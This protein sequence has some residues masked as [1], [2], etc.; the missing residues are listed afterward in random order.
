[1]AVSL[2]HMAFW[3]RFLHARWQHAME[4]GT[5]VPVPVDDA[6]MEMINQ[7]GLP[8]W[9]VIPP[10]IAAEECLT[11]AQ[12]IGEFIERLD[13]DAISQV[14]REGRERLVDRSLHRREHLDT[15]ERAFPDR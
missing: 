10:R 8:A 1:M 2:A 13:A 3:D 9:T 6:P 15:I 14:V 5:A 12:T 4:T 11:A 7:A